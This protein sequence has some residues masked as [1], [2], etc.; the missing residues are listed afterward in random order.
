MFG[1][2][3][4]IL[5]L[6]ADP[7]SF[8]IALVGASMAR[9]WWHLLLVGMVVALLISLLVSAIS[10][11]SPVGALFIPRMIVGCL[12]AWVALCLIRAIRRKRAARRAL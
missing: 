2:I 12:H 11:G 5:G 8:L 10:A 4:F 1:E 9:R 6:S 3:A 7:I